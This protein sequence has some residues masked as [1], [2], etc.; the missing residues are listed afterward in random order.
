V[1]S[2]WDKS[3][4]RIKRGCLAPS[5]WNG[6]GGGGG[7][8]FLC[9][10]CLVLGQGGGAREG[11]AKVEN[12]KRGLRVVRSWSLMGGGVWVVVGGGVGVG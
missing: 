4:A 7:V 12:A 6:G 3:V 1:E 10:G 2:K 11:G 8:L 9:F 5:F